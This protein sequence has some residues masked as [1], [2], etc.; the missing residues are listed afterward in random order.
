[1]GAPASEGAGQAAD[2]SSLESSGV[3]PAAPVESSSQEPVPSPAS[4]LLEQAE[5]HAAEY[6]WKQLAEV[7]STLGTLSLSSEQVRRKCQ[8]TAPETAFPCQALTPSMS[9]QAAPVLQL[10]QSEVVKRLRQGSASANPSSISLI[11]VSLAQLKQQPSADF[12]SAVTE[13]LVSHLQEL[14]PQVPSVI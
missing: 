14:Q 12:L 10:F 1:M 5:Q 11:L 2:P 6:D 4:Q 8:T 3:T 9:V 7:A 13:F